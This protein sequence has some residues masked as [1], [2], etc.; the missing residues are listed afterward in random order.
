M[1][2]GRQRG[3]PIT[4]RARDRHDHGGWFV[5]VYGGGCDRGLC[6]RQHQDRKY[7]DPL[8]KIFSRA[9]PDK[10][11][12][13]EI[14]QFASIWQT[15]AYTCTRNPQIKRTRPFFGINLFV[16]AQQTPRTGPRTAKSGRGALNPRPTEQTGKIRPS[17]HVLRVELCNPEARPASTPAGH[18]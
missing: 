15:A 10:R 9:Y 13:V 17:A 14:E 3:I 11:T 6:D 2:C 1:N 7:E 8:R 4:W 5:R 18:T 16:V 12:G